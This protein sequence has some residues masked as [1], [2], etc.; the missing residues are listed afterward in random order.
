MFIIP[1]AFRRTMIA[2]HGEDGRAWIDRLPAIL[3]RCELRWGLNLRP[4]FTNLS[5]HYVAPALRADGTGV[6]VKIY[7][8]TDEFSRSTEALRLFD[9]HGMARLLDDAV[10]DEVQLLECLVPGTPLSVV[11]NDE[12]AIAHAAT[13]MRQLWQPVPV[14][15]PFPSIIDWGSG[16]ARLRRHYGGGCGPFPP[17]LIE[18]A[19]RLFA[20][21]SASMNDLVLLHG[22]LHQDNI[23]AA[24]RAPWLAIDPKGV[25]GEPA[26][27]I[28]PLLHEPQPQLL[29]APQPAR[30]IARRIDQLTE[31]LHLDR[32]RVRGW[33]L[34]QTVLSAW[35]DVED[36]DR[37]SQ[38]MLACAEMI[39]AIK[40]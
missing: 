25:I 32:W 31:E 29:N 1:E 9:G 28:A 11:E 33:G 4:P 20:E 14:V 19:E 8:P 10:D 16:L 12:E 21:L 6:I 18:E 22:D 5:Y 26:F 40:G 24:A 15:H 34:V 38:A 7:S 3:A 17:A 39:A 37:V 13:V 27:E 36:F 35:W 23:L 30:I 2:L